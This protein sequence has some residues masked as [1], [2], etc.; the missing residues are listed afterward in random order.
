MNKHLISEDLLQRHQGSHQV[1]KT[2]ET[3]ERFEGLE[4]EDGKVINVSQITR[5]IKM[6]NMNCM[7]FRNKINYS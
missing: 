6:M 3:M 2:P 4:D 5:L 1:K 7:K